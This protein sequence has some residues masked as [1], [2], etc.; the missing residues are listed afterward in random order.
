MRWNGYEKDI[1]VKRL[2]LRRKIFR[3]IVIKF[4]IFKMGI[5]KL[6]KIF[7]FVYV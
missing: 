5:N 6:F 3:V 2:M 4:Y 1:L 7:K